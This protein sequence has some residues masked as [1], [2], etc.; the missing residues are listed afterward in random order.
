M[1]Y[2]LIAIPFFILLIGI[3]L[4]VDFF[5]K[6]HYYRINDAI[7]SINAGNVSRINVIYRK[8]IPLTIYIYV[9]H[10]FALLDLPASTALWV[11]AFVIY[12]LCY[13]WKHRMGHEINILWAS[14]VVHHSS[15]EYN[16]STAL[17]QSSSGLFSWV[18]YLPMALMGIDVIMLATVGALNLLYQFWVHTRHIPKLGFYE[19]F[20]VTP[21]NHRVHHATNKR[22][23]D[24]N[25][26]GVFIL[27]D[28]LFG[29]FQ[30]ELD[31]EPCVYGIRKP[32]KSWNPLW[33][34][35]QFYTQLA[36][37]AW[38]TKSWR[39]KL[40]IWVKPTGWRPIDVQ[41]SFPLPEFDEATFE[42][43]DVKIPLYNS[44]YSLLQHAG[45]SVTIFLILLYIKELDSTAQI[46]SGLFVIISSYSISVISE[47]KSW[48]VW[49]EYLRF[50]SLVYVSYQLSMPADFFMVIAS[51]AMV[52]IIM[53]SLLRPIEIRSIDYDQR[54]KN[55]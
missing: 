52:S 5:R 43:Y 47:G 9:E 1:D 18:F 35:V 39:D 10:N 25:Y 42:K 37:D 28:R 14:H 7:S 33:A 45:I 15:E 53:V 36:K 13:Y 24:R 8:L 27:W 38:H 16:L 34:N 44:L 49:L 17:R 46:L 3:E 51:L 50:V 32:L 54:N 48:V 30:E 4:A 31:D 2:I 22:Y 29:S 23:L 6:T 21:S 19:W 55:I 11:S 41:K 20:F 26:G 40:L 12:D